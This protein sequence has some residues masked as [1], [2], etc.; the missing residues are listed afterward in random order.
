MMAL[1]AGFFIVKSVT[2]NLEVLS[3]YNLSELQSLSQMD[4]NATR[5]WEAVAQLIQ[6]DLQVQTRTCVHEAKNEQEKEEC[7]ATVSDF[8]NLVKKLK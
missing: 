6:M 4:T 5:R 7:V 1:G 8:S 2:Y 3:Q